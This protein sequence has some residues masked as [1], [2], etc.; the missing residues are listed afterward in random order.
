[1]KEHVDKMSKVIYL[2]YIKQAYH[3]RRI[4]VIE[5]CHVFS[6]LLPIK[7]VFELQSQFGSAS[8]RFNLLN[9]I[10]GFRCLSRYSGESCESSQQK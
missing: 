2:A 3:D 5:Q 7:F 4:K 1:M 10:S 8:G 9:I 6:P